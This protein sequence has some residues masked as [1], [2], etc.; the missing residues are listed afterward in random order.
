MSGDGKDPSTENF[1]L[2]QE[3]LEQDAEMEELRREDDADKE[4][5]KPSKCRKSIE[6]NND[7][8]DCESSSSEEEEEEIILY[9]ESDNCD[10]CPVCGQILDVRASA[11]TISINV[12]SG[13]ITVYCKNPTCSVKIQIRNLLGVYCGLYS[14]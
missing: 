6:N 9:F 4:N 10:S 13:A 5:V 3:E 12:R 14:K 7:Y 8:G 2:H 11:S 1:E